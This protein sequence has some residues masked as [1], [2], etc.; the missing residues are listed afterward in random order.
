MDG[1]NEI[2][3]FRF[4]DNSAENRNSGKTVHRGIEYGFT[5]RHGKQWTLRFGGTNSLHRYEK[6]EV[7][8]GLNYNKN[9][10]P[11]APQFIANAEIGYRPG[12]LKG[13]RVQLEW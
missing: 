3:S 2:V 10:M 9:K 13:F 1:F 6:Y 4:P 7:K 8:E 5:F 11:S 12:W